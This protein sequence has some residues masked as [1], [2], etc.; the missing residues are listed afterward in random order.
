MTAPQQTPG[1]P[2]PP[3]QSTGDPGLDALLATLIAAILAKWSLDKIAGVLSRFPTVAPQA[4]RYMLSQP[5]IQRM[6]NLPQAAVL[7]RAN[8][9][10]QQRT[11]NAYR[12]AQY[13]MQAA[14]R[15]TTAFHS[16]DPDAMRKAWAKEQE[17]IVQHLVAQTK[18]NKAA[19]GVYNVWDG[20]NRPALLGWKAKMD[21]RTTAECRAADGKNFDPRN[22]PP[23][24]Y[25]GTVHVHCRCVAVKAYPGA[26]RL[27]QDYWAPLKDSVV[28]A[29]FQGGWRAKWVHT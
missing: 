19:Y 10:S 18:R 16:T 2:P 24:G 28:A 7:D 8:P 15:L 6:M 13:L 4:V 26:D 5:E 20:L 9:I 23:I 27:E 21:N 12:R 3:P 25:P 29:S 1:Q 17:Y 22:I 14:Y 11:Q